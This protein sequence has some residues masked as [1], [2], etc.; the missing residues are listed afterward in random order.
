MNTTK[1]YMVAKNDWNNGIE[2][3]ITREIGQPSTRKYFSG[4]DSVA[5][6]RALVAQLRA[7]GF[8]GNKIAGGLD[9]FFSVYA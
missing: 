8:R 5:Q 2:V 6:T 7:A 3:V 9:R 4:E 1:R